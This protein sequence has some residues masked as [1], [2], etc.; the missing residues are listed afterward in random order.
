[1]L[2]TDDIARLLEA[3]GSTDKHEVKYAIRYSLP[4][5]G[6]YI[7]VNK[8]AGNNYSGLV[9]HPRFQSHRSELLEIDGVHSEQKYNHKSSMVKFPKRKN[10]GKDEISYGIPFGFDSE[11]AFRNFIDRLSKLPIAYSS[12]ALEDIEEAEEELQNLLSTEKESIINSRVGQGKYRKQLIELWGECSVTGCKAISLLKASHIKPW[13]DSD[14][15]ERL[16]VYN[17]FLLAP[18]L[19]AAFDAGLITFDNLGDIMISSALDH[20]ARNALGI[21]PSLSIKKIKKE[22]VSYLE[23]HRKYVYQS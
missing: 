7:Y 1:M 4:L 11:T 6:R 14:N 8:Q 3:I 21:E 18:N 22:N 16:D 12:N 10:R 17:G 13:R 15:T 5:S 19:D 20:T 2:S 9:I 23:Y